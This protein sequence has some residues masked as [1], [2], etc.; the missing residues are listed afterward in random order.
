MDE[1]HMNL[2]AECL[3]NL[4]LL[5]KNPQSLIKVKSPYSGI[6]GPLIGLLNLNSLI[7]YY[8]FIIHLLV[9]Y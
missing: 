3:S 8:S 2:S 1:R 4:V 7:F 5:L 9:N 6:R